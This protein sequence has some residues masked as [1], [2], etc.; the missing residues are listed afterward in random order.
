MRI[1]RGETPPRDNRRCPSVHADGPP[2]RLDIDMGCRLL[3]IPIIRKQAA[4][5]CGIRHDRRGPAFF[6]NFPRNLRFRFLMR[7]MDTS[8]S[9]VAHLRLTHSSTPATDQS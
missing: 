1:R 5:L 8:D 4:W 9:H 6:R 3:S 2:P 7:W